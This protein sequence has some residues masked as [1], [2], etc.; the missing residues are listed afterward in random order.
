MTQSPFIERVGLDLDGVSD[1]QRFD[2]WADL[3]RPLFDVSLFN[4]GTEWPVT[5]AD[6][7]LVDNL[8]LT[9]AAFASHVFDRN[10]KHLKADVADC[11]LFQIY[12]SGELHGEIDGNTVRIQPGDMHIQDF[13]RPHRAR[14][15]DASV[16]GLVVSHDLI[17]YDRDRHPATMHVPRDGAIG[18]VLRNAILSAFEQIETTTK[19]EEAAIAGGLVGL[20]RG[21]LFSP[22]SVPPPSPG[23]AAARS[24]AIRNYIAQNLRSDGLT[25]DAI[26]AAFGLSRATL[27]RDFQADG[28]VDRYIAGRRLDATLMTLAFTDSPRGAVNRTAEAWGFSSSSH[29][30]R[31]FQRK[32]GCSPGSVV[33]ARSE[34]AAVSPDGDRAQTP[35]TAPDILP[36]LKKL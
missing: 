1:E 34:T 10:N 30:I 8:M 21:A 9:K 24:R 35:L 11:I 19:A 3:V 31:E 23:F 6:A 22:L 32:F 16:L 29:F 17:G 28:G 26:C 36:L 18:R 13:S 15:T 20:L 5:Q 12:L 33:G 27:Y 25:A 14:T 7:W 2:L 4:T